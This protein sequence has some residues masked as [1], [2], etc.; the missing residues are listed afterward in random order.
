MVL[1][2]TPNVKALLRL[3]LIQQTSAYIR[4]LFGTANLKLVV[5][6]NY[7]LV[8]LKNTNF[9]VLSR[10]ENVASGGGGGHGVLS[11]LYLS[12]GMQFTGFTS[13]KVQILA[14]EE[15]YLSLQVRSLLASLVQKCKYCRAQFTCFTMQKYKY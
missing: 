5:L 7:K 6:K 11:P 1:F 2:G 3:R 9:Q 10:N 14:P 15:L 13:T 4:I 8:V 12:A